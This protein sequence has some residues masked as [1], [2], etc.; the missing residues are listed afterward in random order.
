VRDDLL[1]PKENLTG[2][3]AGMGVHAITTPPSKKNAPRVPILD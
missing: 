1:T 3:D 2:L